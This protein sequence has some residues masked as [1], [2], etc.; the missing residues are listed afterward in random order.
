MIAL[1]NLTTGYAGRPLAC[2]LSGAF[3]AGSATAIIG[4]NG[5][6][7]STLL[8]TIAGLLPPV[9]GSVN[10]APG[11]ENRLGWLPQQSELD[12]QFPLTVHDVVAMGCW[13]ASGMMRGLRSTERIDAA[14]SQVG[15]SAMAALPLN[16]LSGGQFQR[17][18]FA[19]LLAQDAPVMLMD[20]PFT[21]IDSQTCDALLAVIAT[22]H[23]RGK[24]LLVVLHDMETVR[25]HF[26]YTLWLHREHYHWGNTAE[27]LAHPAFEPVRASAQE[28]AV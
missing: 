6:G 9:S 4:A 15:L 21:G 25:R 3:E 12:N 20:E 2:P 16:R 14:L 13:P 28:P 26:P 22:L 7:K 8:K 5:C 11:V 23:A 17:M 1:N 10:Y 19:R 24:T 27:V 18:L